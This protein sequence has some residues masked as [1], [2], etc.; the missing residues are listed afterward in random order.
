MMYGTGRTCFGITSL[1]FYLFFVSSLLYPVIADAGT[2]PNIP[3]NSRAYDYLDRLETR[4]FIKSSII[5]TRPFSRLEGRRLTDEA[6]RTW[7]SLPDNKKDEMQDIRLMLGKLDREFSELKEYAVDIFF[8][9]VDTAYLRYMYSDDR[10]DYLNA[11][12][13][14]D[15]IKSGHNVRAGISSDLRLGDNIS[16]YF[17]PEFRGWNGGGEGQVIAGY[18][19]LNAANIELVIGKEPLWWGPGYHGSILLTNNAM[20]LDM[21]RLT[22]QSP[23]IL[24]WIFKGL[25]GL[26][27]TL[28]VAQ[29]EEDR[30]YSHA[31]LM[32]MRLDFRPLSSFRF[33]LS[34]VIMFGGEGRKGLTISDWF[35]ILIANDNT[36]HSWSGSD[37]DNNQLMSVDFSFILN[38]PERSLP[39]GGMK[40]YGEIGAEDSSG[41]G[42][43]KEKAFLAGMFIDDPVF[44]DN[45]SLRLEWATT[46]VNTKYNTWYTHGQYSSGYTYKGRII[47]HHMG[48][49]AE[50]IFA[51]LEYSPDSSMRI[52]LETDFERS[53]VHADPP[54]K[55]TWTGV[56]VTYQLSDRLGISAGYGVEDV[57]DASHVIWLK[58][59]LAGGRGLEPR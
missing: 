13:N 58:M 43:P 26:K 33:A 48:A 16:F 29:L 45:A 17:N 30:D 51:R 53:G 52:G 11:N 49:D 6:I 44:I 23:F 57:S 42:W 39:F 31:K 10:P 14:G 7:D 54:D 55:R 41:N 46:A 15:D 24:P 47:G 59:D 3:L 36:E 56:D 32:G 18:G 5:S 37:I 21:I 12:N 35:N 38:G 8:K 20:P 34:R 28:F 2:A 40:I 50:D 22:S 27:P 9:P 25:G 1:A 4:G 19:L